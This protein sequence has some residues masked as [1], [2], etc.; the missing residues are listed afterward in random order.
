MH[1][2][3]NY[4]RARTSFERARLLAFTIMAYTVLRNELIGNSILYVTVLLFVWL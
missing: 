3:R 4:N 2:I 1:L